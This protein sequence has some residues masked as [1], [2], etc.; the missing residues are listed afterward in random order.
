MV[1]L[2]PAIDLPVLD[3]ES[4]VRRLGGSVRAWD[5]AA[6]A[7]VRMADEQAGQLRAAARAGDAPGAARLAH[8]LKGAAGWVGARQLEAA[9]RQAEELL[10]A[11]AGPGLPAS[12][13]QALGLLDAALQDTLVALRPRLAP[14]S[15]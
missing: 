13:S 9:A 11:G 2:P 6:L 14:A 5:K 7:F 3:V 15:A 8:S 12:P 4:A 10:L 1:T